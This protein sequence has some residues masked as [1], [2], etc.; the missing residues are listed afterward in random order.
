MTLIKR[1]LYCNLEKQEEEFSL[2]HFWPQ[3]LGGALCSALFKTRDVCRDCNS[4]A[5]LFVDGPFVKSLFLAN[6]AATPESVRQY[7]DPR[8]PTSIQPLA[9]MGILE[10]VTTSPHEICEL[11][12]GACG[13]QYYH[14]HERDA[15]EWIAFT[16]GNPITRNKTPGR[17]YIAF[18]TAQQDWVNL[19]LRSALRYFP[20]AARYGVNV[21]LRTEPGATEYLMQMDS[22]AQAEAQRIAQMPNEKTM[23]PAINLAFD[24]RFMPKLALGLSYN[25]FGKTF[26]TSSYADKLRG[27]MWAK[28]HDERASFG[29]RGLNYLESGKDPTNT[30]IAFKGG[31]TIRIM[32]VR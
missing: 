8:M 15:P 27:Q 3:R 14:V 4:L 10:G 5:G 2:E 6:E 18:T 32:A 25:I 1:C 20:K 12:L 31:Y 29:I 24:H 26:A 23:N 13:V 19:A 21:V 28:T 30:F 17:V 22:A 16:G 7:I 9:Y 11:W